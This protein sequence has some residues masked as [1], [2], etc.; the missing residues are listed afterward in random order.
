MHLEYFRFLCKR[1]LIHSVI[2]KLWIQEFFDDRSL[3]F[4][5]QVEEAG[6]IVQG[7][8]FC[9]KTV[10]VTAQAAKWAPV[11]YRCILSPAARLTKPDACIHHVCTQ[12]ALPRWRTSRHRCLVSLLR[13]ND[14]WTS[15]HPL[16]THK[17]F[18]KTATL[19]SFIELDQSVSESI[20]RNQTATELM[21][22]RWCSECAAMAANHPGTQ[23]KFGH[24]Y[25]K[26]F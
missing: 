26:L 22:L 15:V 10:H 13:P 1:A 18:T 3:S 4:K 2:T 6:R 23:R 16:A 17:G 11:P 9:C 12:K 25:L 7:P 8:C 21:N 20:R 19:A 24:R 5:T 14:F